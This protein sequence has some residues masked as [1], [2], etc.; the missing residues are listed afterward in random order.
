MTYRFGEFEADFQ[1]FELRRGGERVRVDRKVFDL[2][3]YLIEHRDRVI[4]KA[5]LLREV[6]RG[7]VVVDAVV[8]TAVARLRRALGQRGAEG[9]PIQTVH[10]RGYRFASEVLTHAT[11]LPQGAASRPLALLDTDLHPG[12]RDPFVGRDD[13]VQR[14]TGALDKALAGTVRVRLIVGEPGVGKT[15]LSQELAA[16]AREAGTRVCTGH[17][18]EADRGEPLWP[19]L[20]ILR[21][22]AQGRAA[23]ALRALPEP[24]CAELMAVAPDLAGGSANAASTKPSAEPRL[25]LFDA[26]TRLLRE[27]SHIE[28]LLLMLDDLHWADRA[29]LALLGYLVD[30][31]GS[32][33]LM[34]LGTLR[35][36]EL[37]TGHPHLALLE[38]LE[39]SPSFKRIALG[40][41]EVSDVQR[42]LSE[43]TG[44]QP[45]AGLAERVHECTGGNA[46]FVRETARTLAWDALASGQLELSAIRLPESARDVVRRRVSLLPEPAQR[47]LRAASVLGDRFEL[48]TAVAL[49]DSDTQTALGAADRAV[50]ARLLARDDG[51]VGF[52]SFAHGL[53][54]ETLYEDLPSAEKCELHLRAGQIIEGQRALRPSA[55]P[56][57]AFHLHR[58]LPQGDGNR[59]LEYGMLAAEQAAVAGDHEAAARWYACAYEGL[60][61]VRDADADRSAEVLFALARA[62]GASGQEQDAREALDRVLELTALG[63]ASETWANAARRELERLQHASKS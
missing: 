8:A 35:E 22:A 51:G 49:L 25:A 52:Y 30:E 21:Q 19:W 26:I 9:C 56:E 45:P 20:Q 55:I 6:W 16:R 36:V 60:R 14:L 28:P 38:R 11:P 2:L 43:F 29:S 12:L 3:R 53:V 59:V 1:L 18:Y 44:Q 57:I 41:L 37:I 33:R 39:R 32:A 54:R 27:L 61:F 50:L 63:G 7:D 58:A 23:E 13:V 10:G 48:S 62:H 46:F 4:D 31:I 42:Y 34:V 24:V 17:C 15:R 5:E 40:A 47:L